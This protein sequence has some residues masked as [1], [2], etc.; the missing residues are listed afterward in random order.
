[1]NR[2][3]LENSGLFNTFLTINAASGVLIN[4]SDPFDSPGHNLIDAE[5][6]TGPAHGTVTLSDD[7]SF[8]YTPDAGYVGADSFTYRVIDDGGTAN[9]GQNTSAPATVSIF[10]DGI[11]FP[12]DAL[13]S[14][15]Y[16][17]S[18]NAI[19]SSLGA[20]DPNHD[21]DDL[22]FVYETGTGPA[23]GTVTINADGTFT[24]TPDTGFVGIDTFDFR[25]TDPFGDFDVATITVD[26]AQAFVPPEFAAVGGGTLAKTPDVVGLPDGG[27]IIIW[28]T[29]DFTPTDF[30]DV[31]D[32]AQDGVFFQRYDMDG[33]EVTRDGLTFGDD[34]VQANTTVVDSQHLPR[35]VS[36]SDGDWLT[37][38]QSNNQDGSGFGLYAQRYALDGTTIGG[39]FQLN[40]STANNQQRVRVEVADDDSYT[41]VFGNQVAGGNYD[42]AAR[43]FG[44]D[45]TPKDAIDFKV[46]TYDSGVAQFR[47]EIAVQGDGSFVAVWQSAFQDWVSNSPKPFGAASAYGI[48]GQRYDAS[49]VKVGAEFRVNDTMHHNQENPAIVDMAGGGFAV[50]WESQ[51]NIEPANTAGDRDVY[52]K[53]Y[54]AN[55]TAITGE[56][57]VNDFS[58]GDQ[59]QARV[60]ELADGSLFVAWSSN[61]QDADGF[62]IYGKRFL[63]DGTPAGDDFQINTVETNDQRLPELT[64]LVEGGFVAVWETL[65]SA[66]FE[67]IAGRLFGPNISGMRDLTGGAGND[68]VAGSDQKDVIDTKGGADQ[69][70]GFANDDILIGGAGAD[71]MMGGTGADTFVWNDLSEGQAAGGFL[72]SIGDFNT[73]EGDKLDISA[74]VTLSGGDDI[75]DYVNLIEGGNGTTV[76]IDADGLANGT[77]YVSLVLLQGVTGLNAQDLLD[78]ENLLVTQI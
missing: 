1:M 55:G 17:L 43:R 76:R 45:D 74:F 37:L 70:F 40:T 59:V 8:V 38:W 72:D 20:T 5:V 30:S 19:S 41:I 65:A 60:T 22:D 6:N 34:I 64:P 4:E 77:N 75:N 53:I 32:G 54:D 10:I 18:N 33:N 62:G 56:I 47:P 12:P 63:A 2:G 50:V 58:P 26:L 73:A 13:D 16:G 48:Y 7:G 51:K 49:G 35:V 29:T 68:Y 69:L 14:T 46:N 15:L 57:M 23:H 11:N 78:D 3:R 66:Q 25:V 67:Q 21:Y 42:V 24:Y 52:L 27:F 61:L 44:A 9:G 28:A 39:E 71:F 36:F 31:G